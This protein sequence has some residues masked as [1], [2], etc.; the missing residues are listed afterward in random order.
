MIKEKIL[1]QIEL[2]PSRIDKKRAI[3]KIE[4]DIQTLHEYGLLSSDEIKKLLFIIKTE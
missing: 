3:E 2:I 4:N 1:H